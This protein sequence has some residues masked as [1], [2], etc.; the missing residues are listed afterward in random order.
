MVAGR[1]YKLFVGSRS[2]GQHSPQKSY[3]LNFRHGR[4]LAE[5]LRDFG[6]VRRKAL[7]SV[8]RRSLC[9][10]ATTRA[11]IT[12]LA[13][14]CCCTCIQVALQSERRCTPS[15]DLDWR[16]FMGPDLGR[17]L[18]RLLV[19]S[20]GSRSPR[21]RAYM[22]RV[23]ASRPSANDRTVLHVHGNPCY[24]QNTRPSRAGGKRSSAV[25]E[26]SMGTGAIYLRALVHAAVEQ[27]ARLA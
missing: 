18:Q 9:P 11:R 7:R 13:Y 12:R 19:V 26:S 16:R 6:E 24:L 23:A 3:A 14:I 17:N 25:S 15:F 2:P 8:I 1:R 4:T 10:P 20:L 5:R 21:N 27:H 22:G